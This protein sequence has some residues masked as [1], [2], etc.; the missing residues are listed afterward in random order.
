MG[1]RI[2]SYLEWRCL[3]RSQCRL[4]ACTV[5]ESP[6]AWRTRRSKFL[7][8]QAKSD[9]SCVRSSTAT[10]AYPA[11]V[12]PVQA[13]PTVTAGQQFTGGAS[14]S[15]PRDTRR[16]HKH[17]QSRPQA[18]AVSPQLNISGLPQDYHHLSAGW[19]PA[20]SDASVN[21]R[22]P[23]HS[24]SHGRQ[25][26]VDY[27]LPSSTRPS[28]GRQ[29]RASSQHYDP[30]SPQEQARKSA[31]VSVDAG[32]ETQQRCIIPHCQYAA[33]YNVAEQEQ[34]EYCGHGHELCV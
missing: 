14:G 8:P 3:F 5:P 24:G 12:S 19:A 7:L 31:R 10:P 29:R 1:Q 28:L 20:P 23:S 4:I 15:A 33:Y 17:E 22:R 26:G 30:P 25:P 34:M 21:A 32:P 9:S 6:T 2:P 11:L 18:A 27:N 13:A 16:G